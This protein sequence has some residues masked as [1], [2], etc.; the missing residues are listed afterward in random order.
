MKR[1]TATCTWVLAAVIAAGALLALADTSYADRGRDKDRAP[2]RSIR[3]GDRDRD[4]HRWAA[5]DDKD[6]DRSRTWR[7]R[8]W[9]RDDRDC[10]LRRLPIQQVQVYLVP[11]RAFTTVNIPCRVSYLYLGFYGR[12]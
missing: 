8:P 9:D 10:G 4:A 6:R 2:T 12:W 7:D 3:D 11:V 5:R 1:M